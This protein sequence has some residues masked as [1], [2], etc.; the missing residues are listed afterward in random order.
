MSQYYEKYTR[1]CK[2]TELASSFYILKSGK[3]RRL[4]DGVTKGFIEKGELF[5]HSVAL[6]DEN[7]RK[8]TLITE[9]N[10]HILAISVVDI[11]NT[12]GKSLP[13][14]FIRNQLKAVLKK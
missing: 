3:I 2:E 1:I 7:I 9:E 4:K 6:S 5:E 14:I 12:L 13:I 8:E 10:S 11:K